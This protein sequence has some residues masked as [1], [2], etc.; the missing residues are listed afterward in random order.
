MNSRTLRMVL[1]FI[2]ALFTCAVLPAH[3]AVDA[4]LWFDTKSGDIV[5]PQGGGSPPI[6]VASFQW[7]VSGGISSPSIG[8]T[9]QGV[10]PSIVYNVSD[11]GTSDF[12][13][14]SFFDIFLELTA[15]GGT[16]GGNGGTGGAGGNAQGGALNVQG[17]GANSSFFDV[18]DSL[19]LAD[20]SHY[21]DL[22][23]A[24]N[25]AQTGLGG[26]A[27][28]ATGVDANGVLDVTVELFG[29]GARD[30]GQPLFSVTM[31]SVPEPS[32]FALA[33]MGAVAL[34]VM[35]RTRMRRARS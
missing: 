20:G 26:I 22:H 27:A 12:P 11:V 31:N 33:G 2:V 32:T 15:N 35:A 28:S 6:D 8:S 29:S 24:L 17:G 30:L 7:G 21:L 5:E 14:S 9:G 25:P 3:A 23:Y 18:F 1:F 4:F 13:A 19:S 10:M 16:I 34:L